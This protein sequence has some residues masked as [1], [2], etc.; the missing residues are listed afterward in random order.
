MKGAQRDLPELPWF[1][2][3]KNVYIHLYLHL[4]DTWQNAKSG[5]SEVNLYYLHA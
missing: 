5:P 3:F 2:S 1:L 4:K